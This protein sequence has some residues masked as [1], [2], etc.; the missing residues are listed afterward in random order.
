MRL[1][2]FMQ[3]VHDP[4]RDVHRLFMED[5]EVATYLDELGFDE[6][7]CGEHYVVRA[8]PI[9]APMIF[10]AQVAALTKNMKLGTAVINLPQAHP[11]RVA[12]HI[13]FLDHMLEGRLMFG[14]SAGGILADL[15]MFG[16]DDPA[17]YVPMMHESLDI[18]LD[19]WSQE[20]PFRPVEGKY[21]NFKVR[22]KLHFDRHGVGLTLKP[23]Q[24]P[25]P[26]IM[27]PAMSPSS[28]TM[29]LAGERGYIPISSQLIPTYSVASHL[30]KLEEGCEAAGRVFDPAIWRVGRSVFVA[31][32]DAEAEKE[33]RSGERI[34]PDY[35]YRYCFDIIEYSGMKKMIMPDPEMIGTAAADEYT[36]Q[37]YM[38]D[39]LIYGSPETV[40]EKLLALRE[41]VGPFGTLILGALDFPDVELHKNSV[42]L[43]AEE[44]MPRIRSAIGEQAAAQ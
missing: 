28:G 10:L 9:P 17:D 7:W 5:L 16:A 26:P 6:F 22:E 41:E 44:V 34:D 15:E 3:P 19:L 21:W 25:H 4:K 23:Y 40:A 1:G 33:V 32:T 37:D 42:R 8:E 13:A 35:Y 27:M 2:M 30:P 38:R 24:K 36:R 12:A 11:A 39:N 43:V 31:E 20:E 18:I 29:R 14:V